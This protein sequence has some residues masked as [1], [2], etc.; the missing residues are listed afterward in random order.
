MV[1]RNDH[2]IAQAAFAKRTFKVRYALIAII[3][4]IGRSSDGRRS[5]VSV[6]PV[7]AHPQVGSLHTTIH[8]LRDLAPGCVE[9]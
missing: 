4:I 9:D 7:L 8:H 6:R 2:A 3:G 5:F 1:R